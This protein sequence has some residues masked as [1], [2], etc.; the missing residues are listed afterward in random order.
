MVKIHFHMVNPFGPFWSVKYLSF[1]QN[2]LKLLKIH[3]IFQSPRVATKRNNHTFR[4]YNAETVQY[5]TEILLFIGPKILSLFPSNINNSD[6]LE[7]FKQKVSYWKP[8]SF[9]CRLFKT[10]IKD[11]GYL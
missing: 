8:D 2:T 5:G 10:Y 3:F 11:L 1:G 9:P 6:A 4:T 7:M